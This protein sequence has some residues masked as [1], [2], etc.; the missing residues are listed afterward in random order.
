MWFH[1]I[2][3]I[4]CTRW[5]EVLSEAERDFLRQFLPKSMDEFEHGELDTLLQ[6]KKNVNFTNPVADTWELLVEGKRLIYGCIPLEN[7]KQIWE[8]GLRAV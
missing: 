6:G 2:K 1:N 3:P 7:Y 8:D 5:N 4:V